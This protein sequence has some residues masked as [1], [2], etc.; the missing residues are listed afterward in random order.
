MSEEAQRP[1]LTDEEREDL[2]VLAAFDADGLLRAPV[3]NPPLH[4]GRAMARGHRFSYFTLLDIEPHPTAEGFL[5]RVFRLTDAGMARFDEC[6]KKIE[7]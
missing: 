7:Q 3:A 4:V 1:H 2:T 5:L 6:R